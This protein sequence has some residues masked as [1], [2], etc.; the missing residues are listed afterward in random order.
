ML[1]TVSSVSTY[2]SDSQST[3]SSSTRNGGP[4]EKGSLAFQRFSRFS[5]D[6]GVS[7][8]CNVS[9]LAFSSQLFLVMR[10][11]LEVG[12]ILF[13]LYLGNSNTGHNK[14]IGLA[15]NNWCA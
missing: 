13:V 14:R 3:G 9:F 5:Q 4:E 15:E 6:K 8:K 10:I 11:M 7:T 1:A 12:M 2:V